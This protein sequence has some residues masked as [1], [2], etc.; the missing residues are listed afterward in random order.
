[1][2]FKLLSKNIIGGVTTLLL[3][4]LLTQSRL[5]DFL[6][7]THLGRVFLI[8]AILGISWC[9]KIFGVVAVLF[10]IIIFNQSE[11]SFFEGFTD[12]NI[13][14]TT[15]SLD[16]PTSNTISA[17][18]ISQK[19]DEVKNTIDQL[20]QQNATT[21]SSSAAA[22]TAPIS[23]ETFMGREGFNTVDREGTILRGKRS[24]EVPVFS[25]ARNQ[26]DNVEASDKS[27][28]SGLYSSV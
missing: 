6:I 3:I 2:A 15:N 27:V 17:T 14:T 19:K 7:N 23:T 18:T 24:N 1:M 26:P 9:H 20:A 11:I 21:T 4:I 13:S 16:N 22:A 5:F 10:I 8:L 25:N 12:T 28:F